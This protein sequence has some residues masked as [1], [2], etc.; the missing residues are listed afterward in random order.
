M[1]TIERTQ[2]LET[3]TCCNCGVL[4]AMPKSWQR[5]FRQTHQLFYC[6][7]GHPQHYTGESDADTVQRLSGQLDQLKT[8]NQALSDANAQTRSQLDYQRRATKANATRL[9]KVKHRVAHGV[10]PCCNRTFKQLAAHMAGQH[11]QYT[12]MLDGEQT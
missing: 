11:P 4:F 2:T 7:A 10:C 3:E 8:R 6:P 12:H 9:R 5:Q 1:T